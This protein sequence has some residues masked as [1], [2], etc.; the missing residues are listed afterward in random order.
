VSYYLGVDTGASKSH[1]LI[2]DERGQAIG[3][4]QAGPGNWESVGWDGARAALDQV[5]AQAAAQAGIRR[6]DLASAAFGL[7]G[8]DWP[9][10][11][12]GHEAIIHQILPLGLPCTLVNDALI[13]LWAGTDDGYGVVVA[14]GTSCNCYGRNPQG[15]IGRMI[16][17]SAFGEYAGAAEL[18][19]WAVQS[20][21]SAW[22]LR[23]PATRLS[24]ALVAIAGATDV[25]DLLAG[26]MRGRYT[27]GSD[28]APR[29]FAIAS[30][31]D[32]V[33]RQLVRRAGQELGS[34]A[35]GVIRQLGLRDRAFD[36]ILSGSFYRGSPLIEAQM[37]E[38]IHALAPRARLSRLQAPPVVGAV[39]LAMEGAGIDPAAVRQALLRA[40][41]SANH[42]SASP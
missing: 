8:Y 28:A 16:G 37:A 1:A 12:P 4:G 32:P 6:A 15:Q 31:G 7:A 27:L 22:S 38:T 30:D 9:E 14:A 21:A 35:V 24:Q 20:V 29:V 3:F 11:R 26:L 17:A 23:G 34:L 25:A 41:L 42:P 40:P 2:A 36:V 33:A 19:W 13:G 10:D 18:V 39:L 5:I